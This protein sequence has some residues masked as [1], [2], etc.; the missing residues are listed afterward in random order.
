MRHRKPR[1]RLISVLVRSLANVLFNLKFRRVAAGVEYGFVV[2]GCCM[3]KARGIG[4]R[5]S[6]A[7]PLDMSIMSRLWRLMSRFSAAVSLAAPAV[8]LISTLEAHAASDRVREACK[9]DYYQHCSQYSVGTDELRQCMRKVGERLSTPCLAALAQSGEITKADVDRYNASQKEKAKPATPP[10]VT[11]EDKTKASSRKHDDGKVANSSKSAKKKPDKTTKVVAAKGKG[12][13]ARAADKPEKKAR[14]AENSKHKVENTKQKAEKP[15]HATEKVK[16]KP[17]TAKKNGKDSAAG[18]TKS[19][20]IQ[21]AHKAEKKA[22]KPE[23]TKKLGKSSAGKTKAARSETVSNKHKA[24]SP[25]KA[26]KKAAVA[27][28]AKVPKSEKAHS[29]KKTKKAKKV[30]KAKDGQK[31]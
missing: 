3:S 13:K 12:D 9:A 27:P 5:N 8:L 1:E 6:L 2:S 24:K 4:V 21:T 30:Q 23:K 10:P 31:S 29:P 22:H 28:A 17:E 15:K 7:D 11:E 20:Q 19:D 26:E 14:K 18:K 16:H 25:P